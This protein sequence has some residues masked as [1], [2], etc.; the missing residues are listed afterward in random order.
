MAL[1]YTVGKKY[2]IYHKSGLAEPYVLYEGN[3]H[4]LIQQKQFKHVNV[5]QKPPEIFAAQSAEWTDT[6]LGLSCYAA[7]TW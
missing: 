2:S 1:P 3:N 4:K 7:P 6:N 5:L